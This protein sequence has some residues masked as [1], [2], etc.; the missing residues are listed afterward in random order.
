M[1]MKGL[2]VDLRGW[3]QIAVTGDD[4]RRFLHGM[5]TSNIEKLSEGG[6]IRASILNAKGRLMSIV[7]I[8]D[9]GDHHLLLTQPEFRDSTLEFLEQYA[10]V[11]DVE[12]E[13]VA[14]P[15][16][17]VWEDPRSVWEAPPVV[18]PTPEPVARAEEV[19][20]RR[21]EAGYPRYGVDVTDKNFPFETP[22]DRH[23]D[24]T[25]GCYIGQEPVARVKAR[26]SA[27]KYL[28]GL[29]VEGEGA[30]RLGAPVDHL[31]RAGIA[32][33]TSA[34]ESPTFGSIALALMP[35]MAWEPGTRVEIEGRAAEVVELP[36]GG[37]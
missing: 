25:K 6:W 13:P 18:G 20:L 29:R 17:K 24:Y 19:E 9:R 22:L 37:A 26:G 12:F 21:V 4:R 10:M 2:N 28:R 35:R 32:H 15:I 23:I 31:E 1:T 16:H 5:C 33:V 14:H 27:N 30:V 11:D 7:E 8:L 36:F 34:A 3:G